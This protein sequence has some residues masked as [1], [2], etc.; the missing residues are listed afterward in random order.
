MVDKSRHFRNCL[1]EIVLYLLD[2]INLK[3]GNFRTLIK[4]SQESAHSMMTSHSRKSRD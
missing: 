2:C 3:L 1:T 4:A